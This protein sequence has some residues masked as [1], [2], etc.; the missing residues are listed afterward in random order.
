MTD[1]SKAKF[2]R[3]YFKPG[4]LWVILF[5]W[6]L[7]L[8]VGMIF[9]W[10]AERNIGLALVYAVISGL[11]IYFS[12]HLRLRRKRKKLMAWL[13]SKG[14]LEQ[15]ADAILHGTPIQGYNGS[16]CIV[17]E[18]FIIVKKKALIFPL[19]EVN[20]IQHSITRKEI[21]EM[22]SLWV[23]SSFAS[24]EVLYEPLSQGTCQQLLNFVRQRYPQIE[25]T[26]RDHSE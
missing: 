26:F 8:S 5:A 17:T 15:A 11:L 20:T 9:A 24:G 12:P 1:P 2:L 18:N 13:E 19:Q 7:A 21:P 10:L 14:L 22:Q 6:C 25:I 16:G 4:I 3:Q 23:K